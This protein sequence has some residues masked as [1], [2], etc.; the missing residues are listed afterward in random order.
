MIVVDCYYPASAELIF[1][2]IGLKN[3]FAFG[4]SYGVIPWI[5]EWGLRRVIGT[6]AGIM[7]FLVLW[8]LP[9]FIWGKQLRVMSSKWK[10][11]MW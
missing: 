11:I 5:S 8:G 10:V 3:V 2:I 6:M 9:L 4:F 1:L 7:F